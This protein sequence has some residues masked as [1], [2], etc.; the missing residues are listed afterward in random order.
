MAVKA[1]IA[2]FTLVEMIGVLAVI[3]ILGSVAAP[4]IF[5]AIEDAKLSAYI[6]QINTLTSAC[7]VPGRYWRV[8]ATYSESRSSTLPSTDGEQSR[9][10]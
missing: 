10:H 3:A 1:N 8:A 7:E 6:Q 4:K 2:G 9:W 5:A